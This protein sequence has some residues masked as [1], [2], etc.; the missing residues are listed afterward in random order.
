MAEVFRNYNRCDADA[1]TDNISDIFSN[2]CSEVWYNVARQMV[3][4]HPEV[5]VA[6]KKELHFFNYVYNYQKGLEW[7]RSQFPISLN[8]KAVG[9]FTPNY[10][11]TGQDD[12][13]ITRSE[14]I[15]NIPELV[16]KAYPNIKLIVCIRNPVDRAISAYYHQIR[17]GRITPKQSIIEVA[18]RYGIKTIGYYDIHLKNWMNYY[19]PDNFLI[20]IYEEDFKDERK[21][22]TL[23]RVFQFVDV[24][25]KF[26]P[27][28]IFLRYNVRSSHFEM[29]IRHYPYII[30]KGLRR[31]LP[32]NVKMSRIWDIII[33]KEEKQKLMEIFEPH[34]KNLVKIIG[35]KLPWK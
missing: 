16:H 3:S 24:D 20:L 35:R 7:Y 18:E 19:P 29:R 22:T 21:R 12:K 17:N 15:A 4:Q 27:A 9:E 28:G 33:R 10:F 1:K 25:D 34:N 32:G 31:I 30:K 23:E 6:S 2:W 5:S 11:W 13:E 26:E 14:R 8:T